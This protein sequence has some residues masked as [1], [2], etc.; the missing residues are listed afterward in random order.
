MRIV[1][2]AS[3]CVAWSAATSAEAPRVRPGLAYQV[4]HAVTID[5]SFAPDGRHMVYIVVVAGVEQLFIADADGA[6]PRQITHD[7]FGHEDP[8][9]SP[10][11]AR[12]AYVS[13]KGGGE[14]ISVMDPDG[15]H[16][17]AVTPA[18][19]RTIHPSWTPDSRGILYCTDDDL[20]PPKKNESEIAVIDLA[21]RKITTLIT[22]GTNTYPALS[23]DGGRIAFRRMLGETNS[24]V[25]I[26]DADGTNQRNLSAHAAFD[27]WPSWSPDGRQIAFASNRR[28]NQEIYVMRP[29]GSDVRL[30]ANTEGSAT[31]P[32][33]T[34]DGSAI[35][36]PNCRKIDFGGDCQIF[37]APAPALSHP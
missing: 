1:M 18:T 17:E 21:T 25:F 23:P 19:V 22:G 35:Y 20:Q 34:K 32:T 29:D 36:F 15:G 7:D 30:V 3:A 31:A 33:W 11:G 14:V 16:V 28:G 4:T 2:A 10:D 24:E 13:L 27:G 9:W 6:S 37:S 5:P 26:A 12:I 8:S